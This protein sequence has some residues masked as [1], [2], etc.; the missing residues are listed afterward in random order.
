MSVELKMFLGYARV[1]SDIK[2]ISS[3]K[4]LHNRVIISEVD[5]S[6]LKAFKIQWIA[7]NPVSFDDVKFIRNSFNDN[8]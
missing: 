8:Q 5:I 3:F 7:T 4:E 1:T 6:T 2:S